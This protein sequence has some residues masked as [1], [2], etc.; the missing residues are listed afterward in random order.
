VLNRVLRIFSEAAEKCG[1]I[2][3]RALLASGVFEVDS[4]CV[5][6]WYDPKPLARQGI[7]AILY[8][9]ARKVEKTLE[10]AVYEMDVWLFIVK[11]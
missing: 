1:G 6:F 4:N 5:K 10:H 11:K 2:R 8:S 3:R 7:N 9:D